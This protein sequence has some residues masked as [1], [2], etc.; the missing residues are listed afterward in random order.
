MTQTAVDEFYGDDEACAMAFAKVVN[1][2]LKQLFAAGAD[3]VQLDE[4]WM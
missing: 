1:E 3:V 2:E 4:P